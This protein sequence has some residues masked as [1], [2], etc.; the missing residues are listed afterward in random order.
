MP[1]LQAKQINKVISAPIKIVGLAVLGGVNFTTVTTAITSVLATAGNGGVTVPVQTSGDEYS[2]GI[3]TT[4]PNNKSEIYDSTLKT[5]VVDL[6]GNEVYGRIIYS[7]SD[8]K[9]N[10]YSLISGVETAYVTQSTFTFDFDFVY[11]FDFNTLPADYAVSTITRNVNL[12]PKGQNSI[13]IVE[14]VT[15]LGTNSMSP[16]ANV[17]VSPTKTILVVNGHEE[18]YLG[19]SPAFTISGATITWNAGNAGYSIE[20]TDSVFAKYFI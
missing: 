6:N 14:S 15:V 13:P 9:L 8:Y 10:Y 19:G 1:Q 5:P 3:V 17:P 12:D 2:V 7:V 20:T 16:L 11:R 18:Y 4:V